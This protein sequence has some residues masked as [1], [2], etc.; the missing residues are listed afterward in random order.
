MQTKSNLTLTARLD[1]VRR[2]IA[3]RKSNRQIANEI[4]CDEATIRR[5]RKILHLPPEALE[6]IRSGTAVDP[7]LKEDA[8]RVAEHIHRVRAQEE[9]RT[10][11]HSRFLADVI[12][13]WFSSF[14]L[15]PQD[16]LIAVAG[17]DRASSQYRI[18]LSNGAVSRADLL[19]HIAATKTL[20]SQPSEPFALIDYVSNWLLAWLLRAEPNEKIREAALAI[21]RRHLESKCRS[22]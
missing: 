1:L 12:L 14:K 19:R 11:R 18:P 9:L 4:G 20:V 21:T 7:L 16:L 22:W 8:I 17:V 3:Q 6:S 5:D 15:L 10:S 13:E 2:A